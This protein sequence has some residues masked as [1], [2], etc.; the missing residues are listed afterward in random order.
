[1]GYHIQENRERLDIR[2]DVPKHRREILANVFRQGLSFAPEQ[3]T[4]VPGH[5]LFEKVRSVKMELWEEGLMISLLP[6]SWERIS[7]ESVSRFLARLLAENDIDVSPHQ[8][9]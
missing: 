3:K 2:I 7:P 6:H 1:M 8:V 5:P 4:G 9:A